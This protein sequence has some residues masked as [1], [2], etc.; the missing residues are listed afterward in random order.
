MHGIVVGFGN[1]IE[2]I[3]RT[4]DRKVVHKISVPNAEGKE[5][6]VIKQEIL[7]LAIDQENNVYVVYYIGKQ[8]H[9]MAMWIAMQYCIY[10]MNIAI[11]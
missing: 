11:V 8:L 7:G 6:K 1:D 3:S 2:V 10:W 5:G 4:G 9:K